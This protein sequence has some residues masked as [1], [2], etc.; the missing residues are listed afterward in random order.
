MNMARVVLGLEPELPDSF[1]N[2]KMKFMIIIIYN[3][4][5]SQEQ[6]L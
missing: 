6:T 5:S 2:V 1:E 3:C 4:K